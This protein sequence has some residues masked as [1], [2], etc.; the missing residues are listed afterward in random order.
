MLLKTLIP[1]RGELARPVSS[2][3]IK[4]EQHYKDDDDD[5]KDGGDDDDD[6]D[7]DDEDP[8]YDPFENRTSSTASKMMMTL[9][10]LILKILPRQRLQRPG[11]MKEGH[12]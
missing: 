5:N 10:M 12:V 4:C 6:D 3:S 2:E 11:S 7:D 8:K 1:Q 9:K